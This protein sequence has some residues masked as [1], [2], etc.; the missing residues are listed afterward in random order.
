M[1][2]KSSAFERLVREQLPPGAHYYY[3]VRYGEGGLLTRVPESGAFQATPRFQ[4]PTA[5]PGVYRVEFCQDRHARRLVKSRHKS[6]VLAK[7][8]PQDT[9]RV[10]YGAEYRRFLT[11]VIDAAPEDATHY[12][13]TTVDGT[14][15]PD[16]LLKLWARFEYP[17]LAAMGWWEVRYCDEHAEPCAAPVRPVIVALREPIASRDAAAQATA[18]TDSRSDLLS[19]LERHYELNRELHSTLRTLAEQWARIEGHYQRA[20]VAPD[21]TV[22]L[23]YLADSLREA[24]RPPTG[25]VPAT[26]PVK[27]NDYL[28]KP[29]P[30]SASTAAAVA[31][32]EAATRQAISEVTKSAAQPKPSSLEDS[33][34]K[35]D[36][37][38][39]VLTGHESDFRLNR[40]HLAESRRK[41][42]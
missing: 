24:L 17:A 29:A 9:A 15:G 32:V 41:P 8:S 26:Q 30:G 28:G 1:R 25:S 39:A 22:V 3:L 42:T 38:L 10:R 14:E 6:G 33:T 34:A 4:A 40:A 5:K 7:V 20:A 2:K 36:A 37:Q 16:G 11:E 35:V 18:Q 23:K 19:L 13:L 31:A 12:Y 27:S 21:Y